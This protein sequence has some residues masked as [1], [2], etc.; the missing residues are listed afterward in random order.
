MINPLRANFASHNLPPDWAR[1]LFKLS[2]DGES[3]VVCNK[4]SVSVLDFGFF[5]YVYMMGV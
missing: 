3:L 2:K 5:I 4:K 1:D